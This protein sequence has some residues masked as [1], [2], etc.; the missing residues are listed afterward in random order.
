M[1]AKDLLIRCYAERQGDLWV[2][3]CIDFSLAAQAD[4]FDEARAKLS[5]QVR[6]YLD[7]AYSEPEHTVQL[8]ERR[9]PAP[10]IMRFYWILT[11]N[12]L[13]FIKESIA[14]AF[15]CHLPLTVDHRKTA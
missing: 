13:H 4:S 7:E 2:A 3:V 9:A 15:S 6:D 12:R 14:R 8:L 11:A 10:Q 1:H 5:A